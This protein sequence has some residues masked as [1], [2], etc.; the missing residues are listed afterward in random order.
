MIGHS[1]GR[2]LEN[3]L[4]MSEALRIVKKLKDKVDDGD[5]FEYLRM[6]KVHGY[7]IQKAKHALDTRTNVNGDKERR[8]K[9]VP[10]EVL[11]DTISKAF[12]QLQNE[13]ETCVI[14]KHEGKFNMLIVVKRDKYKE[15]KMKTALLQNRNKNTYKTRP[16]DDVILFESYGFNVVFVEC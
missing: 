2:M 7:N 15:V 8:D 14:F 9:G 1:L 3:S 6:G 11:V 16:T 5:G 12:P 4:Y 13:K 10:E